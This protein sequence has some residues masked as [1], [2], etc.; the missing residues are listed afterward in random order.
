MDSIFQNTAIPVLEQAINFAQ[1][2]HAVL[3]S[4]VA[5]IDVP[6]YQTRDLSPEAFQ[7]RLRSAIDARDNWSLGNPQSTQSL[8]G[9]PIG[10]VRESLK[11]ILQH[12]DSNVSLEEQVAEITKNQLEHNMAV[13][14]MSNQFQLLAAVISERA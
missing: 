12:D 7:A 6:G 10:A 2:R 14:I 13:S 9:D 8:A 4:N 11:G 1:A 3:A 5:N